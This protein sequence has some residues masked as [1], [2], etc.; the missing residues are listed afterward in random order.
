MSI[1]TWGIN[2]NNSSGL[3]FSFFYLL[4]NSS[5][6][7]FR[8]LTLSASYIHKANKHKLE[9]AFDFS[10][11]NKNIGLGLKNKI[12]LKNTQQKNLQ[13]QSPKTPKQEP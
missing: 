2:L 6:I 7:I 1:I 11:A 3:S 10:L 12:N 13:Q 4:S 5:K 8:C 9:D